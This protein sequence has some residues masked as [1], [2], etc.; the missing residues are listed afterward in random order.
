MAGVEATLHVNAVSAR[1]ILTPLL[2][3]QAWRSAGLRSGAIQDGFQDPPVRRRRCGSTV[4][5]RLQRPDDRAGYI[6][7]ANAKGFD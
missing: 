2:P 3:R 4:E 6:A 1:R 7:I 5:M